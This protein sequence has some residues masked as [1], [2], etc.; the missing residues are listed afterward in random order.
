M[1]KK[2]RISNTNALEL[3]TKHM[4]DDL[5]WTTKEGQVIPFSQLSDRHLDNIESFIRKKLDW[6]GPDVLVKILL[7]KDYR[8]FYCITIPNQ[9]HYPTEA[10]PIEKPRKIRKWKETSHEGDEWAYMHGKA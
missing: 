10:T 6:Y 8:E 2:T 7:E 1:Q 5:Y 4:R 9:D 3:Y